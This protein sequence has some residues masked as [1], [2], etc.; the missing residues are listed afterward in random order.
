MIFRLQYL[1]VGNIVNCLGCSI[2]ITF[3]YIVYMGI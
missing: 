2:G 3:L 1:T